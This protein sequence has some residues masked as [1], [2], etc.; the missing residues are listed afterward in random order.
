MRPEREPPGIEMVEAPRLVPPFARPHSKR[1][2]AASPARV[3][4]GTGLWSLATPEHSTRFSGSEWVSRSP[5]RYVDRQSGIPG[6]IDS[7]CDHS[8]EVRRRWLA[9]QLA[10]AHPSFR[11]GSSYSP[12]Q[13]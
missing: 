7:R 5:T 13:T 2:R 1:Q 9:G 11:S 12:H 6:E 4:V 8:G 10:R 3:F